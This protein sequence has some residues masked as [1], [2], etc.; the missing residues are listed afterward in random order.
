[1]KSFHDFRLDPVNRCLWRGSTRAA[2]TPKGLDLLE[3]LVDHRDRLISQDEILEALWSRSYVNPEII[4]KYILGVRKVLGDRPEQP[5]YIETVPKRGYRFIAPVRE[6]ITVAEPSTHTDHL[7]GRSALLEQ[8]GEALQ[9]SYA[10]HR[11]I[12]FIAGEAGAGKSAL[13]DSFAKRLAEDSTTRV[14]RGHCVESL[15]SKEAYYPLLEAVGQLAR[16]AS[17]RAVW[18]ILIKQAPTWAIQFPGLLSEKQKDSLQRNVLGATSER[19]LREICEALEQLAS[20]V[21]LLLVLEDLHWSDTSTLDFLSA[22]ARRRGSARVMVLATHRPDE[23]GGTTLRLR[24]VLGDLLLHG[25]CRELTLERLSPSDIAQYLATKLP[26]GSPA[27]ELVDFVDSYCRGNALFMVAIVHD[28]L[29]RQLL[30]EAE[31]GWQLAAAC[32]AFPMDVPLTLQ[33][34]FKLQLDQASALERSILHTASAAGM[35]FSAWELARATECDS[36]VIEAAC[37]ALSDRQR[38]IRFVGMD[39]LPNGTVSAHFEFLHAL[40]REFLYRSISPVARSKLHRAI[41]EQLERLYESQSTDLARVL[42]EHFEQGREFGKAIRYLLIAAQNAAARFAHRESIDLHRRAIDLLRKLAPAERTP[43]ELELLEH[44]G[45]VHYA[46]GAMAESLDAYEKQSTLAERSGLAHQHAHALMCQAVPLGLLDPDR[47]VVLMERASRESVGTADAGL[48]FRARFMTAVWRLLYRSWNDQDSATFA[49]LLAEAQGAA[50]TEHDEM[51]CLYVRCLRGEF[52]AAAQLASERGPQAHTL[53]GYLGA[54]GVAMLALLFLGRLG[55]ALQI[56][57]DARAV[58]QKNGH[59][60]WLFVFREAW[61]RVLAFDFVGAG[62]LCETIEVGHP[63]L[64]VQPLTIAR[65]ANGYFL[66]NQGRYDEALSSFQQ[67]CDVQATPKFF[68]HWYWRLQSRLALTELWLARGHS[69]QAQAEMTELLSGALH[70]AEP[71]LR[72]RALETAARVTMLSGD[73]EKACQYVAESL[74]ILKQ[75]QVPLA[76]WQVHATAR[77]VYLRAGAAEAAASHWKRAQESARILADSL[78]VDPTLRSAF[79]NADRI[80]LLEL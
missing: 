41:A 64:A 9:H 46:I 58:A 34:L 66:L 17:G 24:S 45:D 12:V 8:L 54:A 51:F 56:I 38:F 76:E 48:A 21:P 47:A 31:R 15:G 4:K 10:G 75:Y 23:S 13:A 65:Y 59:D 26:R 57:R 69:A 52:A 63:V 32:G 49:S 37:E 5:I 1:L 42:A 74:L 62:R 77:D 33:Q 55:D 73:T 70:S 18:Q 14:A 36:E 72:A 39:E 20:S 2:L 22:F 29:E 6:E 25:R 53:M 16:P 68:L 11:Q 40:H 28:L 3:Y 79:L 61:L 60:P 30:Q 27:A 67:I 71:T 7:V 44:L 78:S 80:R 43:L 19:M 35:R 50:L